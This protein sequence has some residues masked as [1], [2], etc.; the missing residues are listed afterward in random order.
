M[1]HASQQLDRETE[2][3]KASCRACSKTVRGD[4]NVPDGSRLNF[5]TCHE[6]SIAD[7]AHCVDALLQLFDGRVD[8]PVACKAQSSMLLI[9]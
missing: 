6:V 8:V 9:S 5:L 2:Q 7:S 3:S 1:H 4:A